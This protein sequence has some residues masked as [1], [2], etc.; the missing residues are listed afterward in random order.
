MEYLVILVYLILCILFF[1][2]GKRKGG[3]IHYVVILA[4]FVLVSGLA[5]RVGTDAIKYEEGFYSEYRSF[6]SISDI[7]G[8]FTLEMQ[9]FWHVLNWFFYKFTGE[10]VVFKLCM[11]IFFNGIIFEDFS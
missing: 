5:Y 9:P 10:W 3:K 4:L 2:I 11:A 7:T 6:T 8:I 1:D